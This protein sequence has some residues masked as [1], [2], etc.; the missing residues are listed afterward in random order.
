M[1]SKESC[2]G[3]DW[4][5]A[6][7]RLPCLSTPTVNANVKGFSL[8]AALA[9]SFSFVASPARASM[10][11]GNLPDNGSGYEISTEAGN[12]FGAAL[13]FTPLVNVGFDSVTL[14]ISGYT[15]LDGSS[16]SLSL[17]ADS[18]SDGLPFSGP[19]QTIISGSMTPNDGSDAAFTFNLGGQLKSNTPYWLFLYL[20]VPGGGFGPDYGKFNC[21][22]DGGGTPVGDVVINGSETYVDGF[23]PSSFQSDAPAFSINSVPES[24]STA[25]LLALAAGCGLLARRH[26]RN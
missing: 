10:I 24:T 12:T 23:S 13:E 25:S 9:I 26:W 6:V 14:W 8:L 1:K 4:S 21:Q 16:L 19:A 18:S 2:V 15:G 17:M 5:R 22:W 3:W 7:R 20:Q 11:L